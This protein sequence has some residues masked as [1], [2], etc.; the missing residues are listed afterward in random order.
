[1]YGPISVERFK[2]NLSPSANSGYQVLFLCKDG[3]AL[4]YGCACDNQELIIEAIEE[5]HDEQWQVVSIEGFPE[6]D[7]M[8]C[9]HCN[10]YIESDYGPIL[11]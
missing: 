2:N 3:G 1:M 6:G 9:S 11:G 5:K 8:P 10:E 4:C 7:A